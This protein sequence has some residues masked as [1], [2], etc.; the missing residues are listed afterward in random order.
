MGVP[1]GALHPRFPC[2]TQALRLWEFFVADVDDELDRYR[3]QARQLSA[4]AIQ[5]APD[6]LFTREPAGGRL[7]ARLN[8]AAAAKQARRQPGAG[9]SDGE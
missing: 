8:V 2:P 1:D 3:Q 7:N 6:Q 9:F 5:S 4:E